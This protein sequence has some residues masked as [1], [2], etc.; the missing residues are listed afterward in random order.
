MAYQK[1]L[2]PNQ[3]ESSDFVKKLYV[4]ETPGCGI[5]HERKARYC[6]D[7]ATP[8]KREATIAEFRSRTR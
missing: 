6:I 4:C 7:H 5:F 1:V 2:S 8:E 3:D